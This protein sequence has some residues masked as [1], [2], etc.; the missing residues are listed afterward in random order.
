MN[1]SSR[2]KINKATEILKDT[3]ELLYLIDIFKI[4]QPKKQNTP[5]F[6]V[7]MEHSLGLATY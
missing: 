7:H 6:Q 2:Q 4:L 5:S 3:I 1:R